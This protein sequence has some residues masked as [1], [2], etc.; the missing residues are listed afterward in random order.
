MTNLKKQIERIKHL[1]ANPPYDS[2]LKSE[3]IGTRHAAENAAIGW[4]GALATVL[5][6][7]ESEVTDGL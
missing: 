3:V 7:L 2:M 6:I 5:V 4:M 1:Q